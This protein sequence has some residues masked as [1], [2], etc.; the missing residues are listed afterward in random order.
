VITAS[1]EEDV[2]VETSYV[3]LTSTAELTSKIHS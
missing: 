2:A 3:D 1:A